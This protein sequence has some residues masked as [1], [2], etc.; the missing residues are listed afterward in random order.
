M[1]QVTVARQLNMLLALA[2]SEGINAYSLPGLSMKGQAART[3]D[4][5]VFAWSDQD[6]TLISASKRRLAI[7][8]YDGLEFV[9]KRELLMPSGVQSICIASNIA[10]IALTLGW[11]VVDA[12]AG[13]IITNNSTLSGSAQ[14]MQLGKEVLVT[15]GAR[16]VSIDDKGRQRPQ[17][18]RFDWTQ[19]PLKVIP[20]PPYVVAVGR[21]IIEVQP[22]IKFSQANI[23][24]RLPIPLDDSSA[25]GEE[26]S[27]ICGTARESDGAVYWMYCND[28]TVWNA[29]AVPLPQQ[30][31]AFADIQ[32]Y[33]QALS[34]CSKIP[35]SQKKERESIEDR[36]HLLLGKALL[37]QEELEEAML[38]LG[39]S[40]MATPLDLLRPL[41]CLAPPLLLYRLGYI[42][43]HQAEEE[44]KAY[45]QDQVDSSK[46]I[47]HQSNDNNND[48]DGR[49]ASMMLPYLLSFRNRQQQSN[50]QLSSQA[51]AV[52]L[53]TA[54]LNALLLLPDTG[55]LLRFLQRPQSV[56]LDS[57]ERALRSAG[58]Y[59]ELVEF[60]KA[61]G[62][63]HVALDILKALS[64]AP[65]SLDPPAQGPAGEMAGTPGVWAAVR[66]LTSLE[67]CDVQLV[68][69]HAE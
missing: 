26:A 44:E 2:P 10:Y 51:D 40:R 48:D 19:P 49:V 34:I 50:N 56:D 39:S 1:V 8:E 53:D 33:D 58:R 42:E 12:A 15:T 67:P 63:A 20:C 61:A 37:E 69:K 17:G 60:S 55:S 22:C 13:S 31:A 66:L 45:R 54:I 38:H 41:R 64:C 24:Q 43:D 14:F 9:L 23:V 46:K 16:S 62:R 68:H 18:A 32:E 5:N 59:A 4:A 36:V 47:E 30:A 57:G 65:T 6:R 29:R 3:R 35:Q 28:S 25:A 21:D 11:M 7:F 52:L 27:V